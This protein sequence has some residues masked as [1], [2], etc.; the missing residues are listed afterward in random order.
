MLVWLFSRKKIVDFSKRKFFLLRDTFEEFGAERVKEMTVSFDS[1]KFAPPRFRGCIRSW[2]SQTESKFFL[3]F[4]F[5]YFFRFFKNI[6]KS[7]A[8]KLA[9]IR[10]KAYSTI[11]T[12]DTIQRWKITQPVRQWAKNNRIRLLSAIEPLLQRSWWITSLVADS[13]PYDILVIRA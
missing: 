6:G 11:F 7:F 2:S 4:R 9:C 1:K 8:S 12:P 3:G 5:N 10:E 13:S